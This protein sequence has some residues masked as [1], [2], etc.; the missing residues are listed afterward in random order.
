MPEMIACCGL[1]CNDCPTFIATQ[2]DD[3]D[4][5]VGTAA[6]YQKTYGFE[7]KPEE[8][9]CDGCLSSKGKLIGYCQTCVIRQCCLERGLDNCAVC[10][11]QPC[12]KLTQFHDFSPDAK[13]CFDRIQ[14]RSNR[15]E[16]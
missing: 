16:K 6:F 9:N 8:I 2:N 13:A 3:D 15:I 10:E 11:A 7:L 14:I 4:A 12:E 1:I 5:R